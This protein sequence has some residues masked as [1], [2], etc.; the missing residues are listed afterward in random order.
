MRL[1]VMVAPCSA[2]D[3]LHSI[4]VFQWQGRQMF[5][6]DSDGRFS[7][8]TLVRE[9]LCVRTASLTGERVVQ[10]RSTV[11]VVPYGECFFYEICCEPAAYLNGCEVV[12][13]R[14][15][16]LG[17]PYGDSSFRGMLSS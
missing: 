6:I 12:T 9:M 4:R 14:L 15:V 1:P 3:P 13:L 16:S 8:E 2:G 17:V 11:M 10:V 5:V 7:S